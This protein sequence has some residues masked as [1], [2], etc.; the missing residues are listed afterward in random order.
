MIRPATP[1]D[2]ATICRLIRG[3]A[4]YERLTSS[5]HLDE[6]RLR[7]H[8]FGP[9]PFAEVLLAEEAGQAVGYALFFHTFSSFLCRPTLYLEDVFVVPER[10]GRGH[11][12]ALMAAVAR[13]AVERGCPRLE[14]SVLHW[15][16]PALQFYRGL[17]AEARDEWRV[18]GVQ[19][20]ALAALSTCTG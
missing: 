19:G 20:A 9:R 6:E 2:V 14:W 5:L 11:G 12:K 17:G 7:Q 15:N 8:L 13:V 10:R 3:L 1:A 4:E 18:Y 16:E